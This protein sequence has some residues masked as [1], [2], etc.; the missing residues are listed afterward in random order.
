MNN[1]YQLAITKEWNKIMKYDN[2]LN[3]THKKDMQIKKQQ[4]TAVFF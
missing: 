1:A 3:I 2:M 4:E